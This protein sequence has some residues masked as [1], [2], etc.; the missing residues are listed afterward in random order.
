VGRSPSVLWQLLIRLGNHRNE[1]T[2]RHCYPCLGHDFPQHASGVRLK[3]NRRFVRLNVRYHFPAGY[4][5]AFFLVPLNHGA[6][7]HV[8]THLGHHNIGRQ[9]VLL[10]KLLKLLYLSRE[11]IA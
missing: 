10:R 11:G 7:P 3:L 5:L 9:G 8:V 1:F 4:R 6:F 2:H